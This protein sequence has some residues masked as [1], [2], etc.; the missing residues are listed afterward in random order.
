[1]QSGQLFARSERLF[2]SSDDLHSALNLVRPFLPYLP[3]VAKPD[4]PIPFN[5]KVRFLFVD[6]EDED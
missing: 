2:S 3:E 5:Q 1:M 6:R 4:R